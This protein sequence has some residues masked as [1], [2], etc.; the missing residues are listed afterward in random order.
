MGYS[1]FWYLLRPVYLSG[2][3]VQY[4]IIVVFREPL[5]AHGTMH[6]DIPG[7]DPID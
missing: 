6:L 2:L 7:N 4:R 5:N 1:V 3:P